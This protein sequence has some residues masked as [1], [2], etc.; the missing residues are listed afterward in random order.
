MEQLCRLA[1]EEHRLIEREQFETLTALQETK[2]EILDQVNAL[3]TSALEAR[4]GLTS[5]GPG[6]KSSL[7]GLV[8]TLE[9]LCASLAGLHEENR[10][11]LHEKWDDTGKR[12]LDIEEGKRFLKDYRFSTTSR[13]AATPRFVNEQS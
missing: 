2:E 10:A 1:R 4:G 3:Q 9:G 13:R 5:L 6:E 8:A 7:A 12:L 11:L